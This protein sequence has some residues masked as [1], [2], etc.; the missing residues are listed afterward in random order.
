M[1]ERVQRLP[2]AFLLGVMLLSAG[3][4]K[5]A[6]QAQWDVD[7]AVP[8][9]RTTLT[10]GDLIGDTL[11]G[12]DGQGNVSILYTTRLF[13]LGLDTLMAVPDT[14]FGYDIP[15]PVLTGISIHTGSSILSLITI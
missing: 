2:V 12:T 13:E 6:D 1:N 10:L 7:I 14:S 4:R 15:D 3:C 9:I 8:L 5:E 11:I